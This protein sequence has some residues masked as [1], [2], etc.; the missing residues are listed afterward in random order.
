ML[1]QGC[2]YN[3]SI[4]QEPSDQND[5]SFLRFFSTDQKKLSSPYA[6]SLQF[7]INESFSP[8]ILILYK[9]IFLV[10]QPL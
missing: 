6:I 4:K 3:F 7:L 2:L 8:I 5:E 10:G 9:D 1:L